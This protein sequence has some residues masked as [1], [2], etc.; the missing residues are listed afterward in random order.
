MKKIVSLACFVFL[1]SVAVAAAA[2]EDYYYL[3]K[4]DGDQY[5]IAKAE[6]D[7]EGEAFIFYRV[8]YWEM[9]YYLDAHNVNR[10][11]DT[12]WKSLFP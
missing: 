6:L 3:V 8:T 5:T 12:L 4:F 11:D 9:W 7:V 1:L 10:Q 2:E